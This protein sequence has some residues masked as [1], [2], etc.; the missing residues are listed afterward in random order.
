MVAMLSRIERQSNWAE[1]K[2]VPVF[3]NRITIRFEGQ[4]KTIFTNQTVV[5]LMWHAEI[6]GG[7]KFL[8]VNEKKGSARK[9][10]IMV[11]HILILMGK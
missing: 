4:Y 6:S 10:M 1:L 11:D 3:S 8:F 2:D 9:E 5:R 7:H